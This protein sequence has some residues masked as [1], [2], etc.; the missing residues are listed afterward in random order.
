LQRLPFRGAFSKWRGA[1]NVRNK[2]EEMNV[3]FVFDVF[4][5]LTGMLLGVR[6]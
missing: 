5:A 2:V 1:A 3:Y 4:D 6:G